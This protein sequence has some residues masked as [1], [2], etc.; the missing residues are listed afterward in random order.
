MKVIYN[1]Y[2]SIRDSWTLTKTLDTGE[3][4]DKPQTMTLALIVYL[5]TLY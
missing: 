5:Q 4:L 1:F 2:M 3:T